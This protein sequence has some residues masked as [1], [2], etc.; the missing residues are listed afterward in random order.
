[1][2]ASATPSITKSRYK[3]ASDILAQARRDLRRFHGA[4][5]SIER[6]LYLDAYRWV[7][8]DSC[9]WPFSFRHVCELLNLRPET[10][11][12]VMLRDLPLSAVEYWG[13]RVGQLLHEFHLFLRQTVANSRYTGAT[14]SPA[15]VPNLS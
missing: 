14:E 10:V 15:L 13:R 7:L 4:T 3:L 6:E 12:R 2:K 8:S 1:V 11:R 5:R 9:S